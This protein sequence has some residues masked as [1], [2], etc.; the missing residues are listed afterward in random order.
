MVAASAAASASP[1]SSVPAPEPSRSG[2]ATSGESQQLEQLNALAVEYFPTGHV[3][4]GLE[5]RRSASAVPAAQAVQLVS[6][7]AAK[8]L[9]QHRGQTTE[10]WPHG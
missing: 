6:L 3:V 4:H 10:Q 8:L 5:E 7:P 1:I 9:R 2:A